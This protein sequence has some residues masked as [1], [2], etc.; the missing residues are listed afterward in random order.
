MTLTCT[1]LGIQLTKT[2]EKLLH[3]GIRV[4]TLENKTIYAE[5]SKISKPT[6]ETP[7]LPGIP[8]PQGYVISA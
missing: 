7:H 5:L 2:A 8:L 4:Y 1:I 6:V 3:L